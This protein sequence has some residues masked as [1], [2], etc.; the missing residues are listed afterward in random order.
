MTCVN[1]P[2]WRLICNWQPP[3]IP[4][5]RSYCFQAPLTHQL[6]PY[7]YKKVQKGVPLGISSYS[8]NPSDWPFP[9]TMSASSHRGA[10]RMT[11]QHACGGTTMAMLWWLGAQICSAT[12]AETLFFRLH[13]ITAVDTPNVLKINWLIGF[14]GIF[15]HK[16]HLMPHAH[17]PC[18]RTWHP[19]W[20]QL[21]SCQPRKSTWTPWHQI[22]ANTVLA[23]SAELGNLSDLHTRSWISNWHPMR[24]SPTGQSRG[25]NC[26]PEPNDAKRNL[27]LLYHPA[28]VPL[29]GID[30]VSVHHPVTAIIVSAR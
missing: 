16:T 19:F 5:K 26:E 29:C 13:E 6:R 11:T 4:P 3:G 14:C 21:L 27:Q 10:F 20:G 18:F 17:I 7:Q 2:N 23:A 9:V 1:T 24:M 30:I 12:S 28:V 25:K 8:G 22:F 15:A